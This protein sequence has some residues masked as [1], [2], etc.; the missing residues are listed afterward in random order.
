MITSIILNFIYLILRS[1]ELSPNVGFTKYLNLGQIE[2]GFDALNAISK[3]IELLEADYKAKSN[4]HVCRR[5]GC[6]RG[7][8]HPF[9]KEWQTEEAG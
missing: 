9:T 7:S 1:I 5:L 6:V 4:R 3:A 2:S 8:I